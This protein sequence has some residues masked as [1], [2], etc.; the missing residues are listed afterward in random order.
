MK[1]YVARQPI[2]DCR[3]NPYGYEFLHRSSEENFYKDNIDGSVATR[4]LLASLKTEFNLER[5]TGG[6]LAFVNFTAE[7]L[8]SEVMDIIDPREVIVE[9]LETVEPTEEVL[10][11]LRLLRKKGFHFALD[12]YL[13]Q[14]NPML[15]IAEIIKVDFLDTTPAQQI[16]IAQKNRGK[17]L[18]AEKVETRETFD[19][20]RKNGYKLFQGFFFSKPV[21]ISRTARQIATPIYLRLWKAI[22][23][24]TV[25]FRALEVIIREDVNLTFKVLT[26][27]NSI[28]YYRGNRV[29]SLYQAL[30]SLGMAELKRWFLLLLMRRCYGDEDTIVSKQALTRAV[31][32]ERLAGLLGRREIMDDAYTVG[33]FSMI[34]TI[35]GRNMSSLLQELA[36]NERVRDCLLG[37]PGEL[38]DLLWVVQKYD[39]FQWEDVNSFAL[40]HKLDPAQLTHEYLSAVDYAEVAFSDG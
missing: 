26:R 32:A 13:G 29:T 17:I 35:M 30:V 38:H 28:V 11:C 23:R 33:L 10:D 2:V 39:E 36:I 24:P 12:D 27:F 15:E 22:N 14:E 3:F 4:S 34:D 31:F 25:T 5:L 8:L 21:V 37:K 19:F 18:L 16:L 1:L 6:A 20:A 7:V 40:A 9:I